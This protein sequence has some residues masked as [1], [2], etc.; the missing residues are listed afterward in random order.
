M[1]ITITSTGKIVKTRKTRAK[2]ARVN[3]SSEKRIYPTYRR[4]WTTLDYVAAYHAAN[5]S[6]CLTVVDYQCH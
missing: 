6:V 1:S 3:R 4:G 2:K 5:A